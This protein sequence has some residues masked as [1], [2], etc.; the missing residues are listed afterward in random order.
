MSGASSLDP[1]AVG[2]SSVQLYRPWLWPRMWLLLLLLALRYCR[3]GRPIGRGKGT[4][5]TAFALAQRWHCG[6]LGSQMH[7][8]FWP[9]QRSHAAFGE[10]PLLMLPLVSRAF[11]ATMSR[12]R[13]VKAKSVV[14][15]V[16]M[17]L[18]VVQGGANGMQGDES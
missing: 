3:S 6:S 4:A 12:I 15:T 8:S 17:K 10:L 9:R 18:D 1:G 14:V 7:R 2:L 5:H 13:P 11:E 16:G